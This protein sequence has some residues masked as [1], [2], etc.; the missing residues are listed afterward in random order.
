MQKPVRHYEFDWLRIIAF[1]LLIFFHTG[2]LFVEWEWHIKNNE[3]SSAIEWPMIFVGQW[4]MSLI[5][6][7]SGAGIYFA[8]GYRSDKTFVKD[9]LKRILIPLLVGIFLVVAPQVYLER[10]T[11]GY[12]QNYFEFYRS[13]LTFSPYP[14]GNFTWHHL[15]F[16]IYILV[17]SL[18]LIPVYVR[19]KRTSSNFGQIKNW[20][21]FILPVVWFVIGESWLSPRFPATHAFYNDWYSHYLYIS[22]LLFGFTIASSA[23]LQGKVKALRTYALIVVTVVTILHFS[24]FWYGKLGREYWSGFPYYILVAGNRWLWILT[25]LGYSFQYLKKNSPY[26][27]QINQLV[28][29]YYILHQTVIIVLGYYLMDSY[30]SISAKF[31]FISLCTFIICYLMIRFI[32]MRVNILRVSFGIAP[33]QKKDKNIQSGS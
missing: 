14:N 33:F 4:R 23:T 13:F 32:I 25:I 5:F 21:I 20:M 12:T 27:A 11:Q 1:G 19:I 10:L 7:I 29:P 2:M 9:R 30:W 6:L 22:M 16:L 28:Y 17:Y 3:I 8:L 15:W 26:L 31:W 18:L 24:L